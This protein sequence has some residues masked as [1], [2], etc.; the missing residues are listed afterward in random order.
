WK[1][2][3]PGRD[4]DTVGV[5]FGW[6]NV[7]HALRSLDMDT[8]FFTGVSAPI[9]SAEMVLELTYQAKITPWLTV[10]P[11]F[12]WVIHPGGNAPEPHNRTQA[13]I[14]PAAFRAGGTI[15]F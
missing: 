5:A 3:F 7:S 15:A 2:T 9:Q 8:N 4:D 11:D 12:Q 1:G 13:L 6:A 10:Q 14:D